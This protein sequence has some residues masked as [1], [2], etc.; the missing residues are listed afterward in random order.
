M[1]RSLRSKVLEVPLTLKQV[2][3]ANRLH[4]TML[5]WVLND[6]ALSKLA[7]LM[8]GWSGE[9]STIKCVSINSLY[10]T[11]VYAIVRM[12]AHVRQIFEKKFTNPGPE[13]VEQIAR[14]DSSRNHTSF[15]SKLCHFFVSADLPIYDEVARKTLKMHLGQ[16]YLTSGDTPYNLYRANLK[17][18]CVAAEINVECRRLDRYLWLVGMYRRW[19]NNKALNSEFQPLV[20]TPTRLQTQ[21]LDK[22]L[23]TS[24]ERRFRSDV[25]SGDL[26]WGVPGAPRVR[27]ARNIPK[28]PVKSP[29]RKSGSRL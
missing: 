19:L 23:P 21:L 15:A 13:L 16:R 20:T 2:E 28:P 10:S 6:N 18:L 7:T 26:A 8:P 14:L 4:D 12:A 27:T 29:R 9:E 22:L 17:E 1:Q 11:Q 3:A 24:V 5:Q 25:C